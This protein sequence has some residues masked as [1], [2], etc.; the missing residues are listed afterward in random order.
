MLAVTCPVRGQLGGVSKVIRMPLSGLLSL[1][2]LMRRGEHRV[3]LD[4]SSRGLSKTDALEVKREMNVPVTT[5]RLLLTESEAILPSVT[6][7]FVE[8]S[9][10]QVA[11]QRLVTVYGTW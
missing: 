4:C 7:G 8:A 1:S 11:Y 6:C 3:R 2:L 9:R 5:K 10:E